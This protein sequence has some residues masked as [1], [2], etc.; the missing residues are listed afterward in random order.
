[1]R[2]SG[3]I[4]VRGIV[5]G[6]GFRP[7][8]YAT[9]ES[10]SIRGSVTN[11]G[12]E[13]HIHAEG[14]R[15]DEFLEMVRKG[16]RLAAIDEVIVSPLSG[17]IPDH[18]SIL[19]SK[20]GNLSGLIPPDV[21]ICDACINDIK[22]RNSRY[23]NYWATSCVDCGPRYSIIRA[24]PYDRERTTM[25]HFPLCPS[26][27]EE[28]WSPQSRRHHAQ[29]I[30]CAT[31]GPSL[32]L[33]DPDGRSMPVTDP[34]QKAAELLDLGKILAIRGIGGF[35]I[36][37]IESSAERLKALL[38][39]TE[40]PLAVMA[41]ADTIEKVAMLDED[42]KIQLT[43][44]ARPIVVLEKRDHT[45]HSTIS[46]LHTLGMMLPYTGLHHLVFSRLQ[47]PM[48]VMTS[49]NVPGNPMITE[50]DLVMSRLRGV[51]DYFLT[52]DREIQNRCDD[53]VIRDGLI[54]RLSRGIAP[55]RTRIDLGTRAILAV[56]P[57][58]NANASIYN[59][60]FC[61][62]SP[63]IGNIRNPST[64]RY[65]DETVERLRGL[66]GTTPEIIACDLHPQFLSTRYATD[67]ADKLGAELVFVQHHRAHI[68]A[69]TR[70]R[71][72]GIAIDGVGYGD[73]GTVWGGEIFVG[74][75][76]DYVRAGHL[77]Q[78][79]M[80]G[81]DAATSHPER[82]LYGILQKPEI[83]DLLASRGWNEI[84][85]SALSH[86]VER[87]FN[88]IPT[89]STG[90]VLDAASALLGICSKRTYDGEPAMRLEAAAS[91]G[92]AGEWDIF[93]SEENGQQVLSTSRLM[94][95]A[96]LRY[97]PLQEESH[98][99]QRRA[100]ADIAA[101]F[102]FNLARG[103]ALL[104]VSVAEV[105]GIGKAALSGGVCYNRMIRT[106]ICDEL[107][108]AGIQPIINTDYP[109]GDGC[110]SYGQAIIAGI[111]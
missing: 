37:C 80:P 47:A 85:C 66:T 77:E 9:A 51:V 109:L 54:I 73:D 58:L 14:D 7:F 97:L 6:V 26:C 18:F 65:L 84:A 10:L 108:K 82:M 25:D 59:N 46:N 92:R 35:H 19:D 93:I 63:H 16:P 2:R 104:A 53:S 87:R 74:Q 5:Q 28:Y 30:A 3:T 81:G 106:T 42:D 15:F 32:A 110:I 98:E 99:M 12:S 91:A 72:V 29:T 33:M 45:S 96:L 40:Q 67:L 21:A 101:S 22:Q 89:T 13:V 94:E 36:A 88:T 23:F 75:A 41:E 56:G 71:C 44:P 31:C 60:G 20:T 50:I 102:Q 105:N 103:I 68:A 24:L 39:R 61:I 17:T 1:M 111:R 38:G 34:I 100:I 43:S 8:V 90:R 52:H 62:T 27:E 57:E 78:V 95:E 55:K 107:Q 11:L 83:L 64:V 49:A 48:L 70:E 86:Q 79:L 69:A 4:I 76:P